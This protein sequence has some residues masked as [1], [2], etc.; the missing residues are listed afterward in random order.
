PRHRRHGVWQLVQVG[1]VALLTIAQCRALVKL[2]LHILSQGL[3]LCRNGAGSGIDVGLERIRR[4]GVLSLVFKSGLQ[5]F[6]PGLG[7]ACEDILLP[8]LFYEG[9]IVTG[10][11]RPAQQAMRCLARVEY[12]IDGRLY[13]CIVSFA[14][15][16]IAPRLEEVAAWRDCVQLGA[17]FVLAVGK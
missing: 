3:A 6:L 11:A 12:R 17:G 13:D 8:V 4:S 15:V 9:V 5:Y 1:V 2:Y 10:I 16:C 7:A 14:W